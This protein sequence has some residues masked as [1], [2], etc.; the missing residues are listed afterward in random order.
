MSLRSFRGGG[1]GG[2]GVFVTV[3][4]FVCAEACDELNKM[5]N[6]DELRFVVVSFLSSLFAFVSL[7]FE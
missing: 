1:G 7:S 3:V 2:G 6:E 4:L 5:L